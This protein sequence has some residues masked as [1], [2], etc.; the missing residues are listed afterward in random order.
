MKN[1]LVKSLQVMR[2]KKSDFSEE[3][4]YQNTREYQILDNS[5]K[6]IVDTTIKDTMIG[7]PGLIANLDAA[8]YISSNAIPGAIIEC[9][10]W[11]GGSIKSI[12][13]RLKQLNDM[14][15]D[16]YLFDTFTG[17]TEPSSLDLS[18]VGN[19]ANEQYQQ[20]NRGKIVEWC[21]AP[22]EYVN[23]SVLASAY[24]EYRIHLVVGDVK[25]T[26]PQWCENIERISILRLDTDWY[27]STKT[28]MEYFYPKLVK[29]G[30]LI[31][32]DYGHWQG[33]RQAI[34][35]YFTTHNIKP[36]LFRIDYTRRMYIK[37]D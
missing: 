18:Y 28:E 3:L 33:A 31:I 21:Y 37:P 7:L 29:G 16:V 34:D 12:L 35:E 26:I 20:L 22:K 17:M 27:E 9:G 19:S 23:Q 6:E 36:F 11:K 13:L 25:D 30:V 14:E 4:A 5:Y 15:R 24:P 1:L 8:S 10:V 2:F 32:D